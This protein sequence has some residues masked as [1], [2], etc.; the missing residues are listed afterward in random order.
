MFENDL[1]VYDHLDELRKR[2]IITVLAFVVFL[3]LG[4]VYSKNIYLFFM[5]NL[6]YKLLV[7]G[8][9]DIIWIY[10]HLATVVAVGGT[11]P[12]AAWQLWLFIKPALEENERKIALAYIPALFL[13]FI[14]GLAFGYFFIFP[15]LMKFL[16]HLGEGLVVTSFTAEKYFS[17]LINMTF[18]FGLAFELPPVLMLLTTLGF[19]NPY[20]IGKL[21][22]YAY[23]I[24]VIIAS[25]ISPPEI[26][27]HLSVAVPLI[28][29]YEI[30]VFF[31]KNVYKRR[32]KYLELAER[33]N[34]L[35]IED[36][37]Q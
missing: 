23:L 7:L 11:I 25:M 32:L 9:S 5:G 13:L 14:S 20:T 15:N 10:F 8:P 33:E 17:F 3:V 1:N 36:S 27:S 19:V 18:P 6:G 12:I 2:L 31:S 21:R 26:M 22:K 35:Q 16:L 28:F 34:E 29:I 30:S 37:P 24:L 4:L